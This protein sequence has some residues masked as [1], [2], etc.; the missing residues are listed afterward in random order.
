ML[1]VVHLVLAV[2]LF[3]LVNFVGDQNIPL[4]YQSISI[5]AEEDKAPAFNLVFRFLAPLVYLVV[6]ATILYYLGFDR[7]V[8][9]IHLVVV[10]Y[11]VL[12]FLARLVLGRAKLTNWLYELSLL[13]ITTFAARLL[14]DNIISTQVNLLPDLTTIANELWIIVLLFIYQTLNQVKISLKGKEKRRRAYVSQAYQEYKRKFSYIVEK[15]TD[16]RVQALAYAIIIYESYN[17][18]NFMRWLERNILFPIGKS[19]TL[20]IMQVTTKRKISDAESVRQGIAKLEIDYA[21]AFEENYT[22]YSGTSYYSIDNL[23]DI[24]IRGAIRR[25]NQGEE[26][27][28]AVSSLYDEILSQFYPHLPRS[29]HS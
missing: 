1:F 19:K 11:F 3:F 13:L 22:H 18:P 9:N 17:R 29:S 21:T 23:R 8:Q 28:K 15:V 7:F 26:Y 4:G 10:Y 24:S 14:Y 5:T 27:Y 2:V 12:R 16:E 6:V 25:Y 20:G